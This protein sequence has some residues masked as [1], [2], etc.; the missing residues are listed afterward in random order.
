MPRLP[1]ILTEE[2]K[3]RSPGGSRALPDAR[4]SL[5]R[6]CEVCERLCKTSKL[7]NDA[8]YCKL[9][10]DIGEK[11]AG[12]VSSRELPRLDNFFTAQIKDCNQWNDAENYVFEDP[13]AHHESGSALEE[14]TQKGCHLCNLLWN[15]FS[16]ERYGVLEQEVNVDVARRAEQ[17]RQAARA[18]ILASKEPLIARVGIKVG[19]QGGYLA[20]VLYG[21]RQ[22]EKLPELRSALSVWQTKGVTGRFL[23]PSLP[24]SQLR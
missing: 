12:G 15:Y 14:S 8:D 19:T 18:Q 5:F 1:Q 17:S 4:K 23:R 13:I 6:L 7:L 21:G 22:S 11:A 24:T 10:R 20:I 2:L 9:V 16:T 3:G